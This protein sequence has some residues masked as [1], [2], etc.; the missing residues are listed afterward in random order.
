VSI[1]HLVS[2]ALVVLST[3]AVAPLPASPMSPDHGRVVL[4]TCYF[5]T[6]VID[7]IPTVIRICP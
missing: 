1:S 2:A 4:A 3:A 6:I 7:G 5:V